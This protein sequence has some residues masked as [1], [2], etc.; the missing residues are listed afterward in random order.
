MKPNEGKWYIPLL[1]IALGYCAG[2]TSCPEAQVKVSPNQIFD[3]VEEAE[4]AEPREV[5]EQADVKP[6]TG[7]PKGLEMTVSIINLLAVLC[8]DKGSVSDKCLDAAIECT[9][10][11]DPAYPGIAQDIR[12]CALKGIG[13]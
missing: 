8:M 1:L 11:L 2:F 6:Q 13:K 4:E 7:N 10:A 12:K 3:T 9:L 5:P